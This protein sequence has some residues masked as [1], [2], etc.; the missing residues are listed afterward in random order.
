MQC[1]L[2]GFAVAEV[3]GDVLLEGLVRCR[4]EI[5]R[6]WL[7]GQLQVVSV[8]ELLH[9]PL[10][11]MPGSV[12][13]QP[14]NQAALAENKNS[15]ES[16]VKTTASSPCPPRGQSMGSQQPASVPAQA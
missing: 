2:E 3:L 4:L 9:A 8:W 14:A 5:V 10:Y 6:E 15:R 16:R 13:G 12:R 11:I 7:Q 1:L